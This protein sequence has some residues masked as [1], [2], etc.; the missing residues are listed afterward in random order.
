MFEALSPVIREPGP[1]IAV[2]A[3]MVETVI[4]EIESVPAAN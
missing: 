4:V 2:L 1:I 3:V